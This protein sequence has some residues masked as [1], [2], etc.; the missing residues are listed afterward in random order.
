MNKKLNN[1]KI[2]V[3][4]IQ[5]IFFMIVTQLSPEV[6]KLANSLLPTND[7]IDYIG[8]LK[9]DLWEERMKNI[10]LEERNRQLVIRNNLM[11]NQINKME[12]YSW[13]QILGCVVVFTA[14]SVYLL[15]AFGIITLPSTENACI[16]LIDIINNSNLKQ[17]STMVDL[18]SDSNRAIVTNHKEDFSIIKLDLLRSIY[19]LNKVVE[20]LISSK[21]S[22]T[23]AKSKVDP[24]VLEFLKNAT[25]DQWEK[26]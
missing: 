8:S 7:S 9:Q 21:S 24:D 23:I 5:S 15:S 2:I 26:L 11:E 19:I 22:D 14:S 13:L 16:S 6:A 1:K 18:V 17:T 4:F 25:K 12:S 3:S 10:E 20:F